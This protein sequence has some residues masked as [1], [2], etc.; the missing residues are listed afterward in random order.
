[1]TE[2][3]IED[4]A[5]KMEELD[6]INGPK[7]EKILKKYGYTSKRDY[8][9]CNELRQEDM[10]EDLDNTSQWELI[11]MIKHWKRYKSMGRYLS[12]KHKRERKRLLTR[13]IA[14]C[15][16]ADNEELEDVIELLS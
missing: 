12:I 2:E 7:G 15:R 11:R 14:L 10:L 16:K 13:A 6:K 9:Q 5:Q 4:F 8:I 3:Q 1:M